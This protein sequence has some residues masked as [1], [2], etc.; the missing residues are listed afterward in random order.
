[1]KRRLG[2]HARTDVSSP[3]QSALDSQPEEGSVG[4]ERTPRS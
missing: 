2:S 4:V 1:M 3:E